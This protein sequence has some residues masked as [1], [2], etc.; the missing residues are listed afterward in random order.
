METFIEVQSVNI[1]FVWVDIAMALQRIRD[2][3]ILI[4]ALLF[5]WMFFGTC[6]YSYR[7][8]ENI[9]KNINN[10]EK[11]IRRIHALLLAGLL[12]DLLSNLARL[13]YSSGFALHITLNFARIFTTG[14]WF[15]HPTFVKLHLALTKK[16][17]TRKSIILPSRSFR[18]TVICAK[19]IFDL[20]RSLDSK[21]EEIELLEDFMNSW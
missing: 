14:C 1:L 15:Y 16:I 12:K 6:V 4:D 9:N 3:I 13:Q 17:I 5:S 19:L 20:V 8:Y 7:K 18:A 10:E 11:T 21:H 2:V